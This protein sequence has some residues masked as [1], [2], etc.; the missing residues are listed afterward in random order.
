VISILFS[1]GVGCGLLATVWAVLKEEQYSAE[2]AET[3][4]KKK[5]APSINPYRNDRDE[6]M[7][8]VRRKWG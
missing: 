5:K 3:W 8:M 2:K 6:A 7:L 4:L 1:E